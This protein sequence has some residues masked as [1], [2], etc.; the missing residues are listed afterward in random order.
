M[1]SLKMRRFNRN[2]GSTF[3]ERRATRSRIPKTPC[4]RNPY[5]D[6]LRSLHIRVE[7]SCSLGQA[8][9]EFDDPYKEAH[10][11]KKVRPGSRWGIPK[12]EPKEPGRLGISPR[13]QYG[14]QGS[15][16]VGSVQR[17]FLFLESLLKLRGIHREHW[18]AYCSHFWK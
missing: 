13:E 14:L 12:R 18:G 7:S 4:K 8:C 3:Q 17:R 15:I 9:E 11:S 16:L 6:S 5:K 2:M 1:N 10:D